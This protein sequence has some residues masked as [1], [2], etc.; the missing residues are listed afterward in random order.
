M[1]NTWWMSISYNCE[2]LS[3][4]YKFSLSNCPKKW[5][6]WF[7][8]NFKSLLFAHLIRRFQQRAQK[9]LLISRKKNS[10]SVASG[11]SQAILYVQAL[12]V[13]IERTSRACSKLPGEACA[14]TG[15]RGN[16]YPV[17]NSAD[18]GGL[19]GAAELPRSSFC[20]V[21]VPSQRPRAHL[22]VPY[23]F[24]GKLVK[25]FMEFFIRDMMISDHLIKLKWSKLIKVIC[26]RIKKK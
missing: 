20:P 19:D 8:Q 3:E 2:T 1:N 10:K 17:W 25:C 9:W 15:T 4:F 13:L 24:G 7:I 6:A 14:D 16:L 26:D 11:S 22:H 23:I 21:V 12:F 18:S 5:A